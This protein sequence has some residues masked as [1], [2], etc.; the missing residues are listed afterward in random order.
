MPR[1]DILCV[2]I[3]SG[4]NWFY[5]IISIVTTFNCIIH[6]PCCVHC[7][8]DITS[9]CWAISLSNRIY[10]CC[11]SLNNIVIVPAAEC[12]IVV[13]TAVLWSLSSTKIILFPNTT[14]QFLRLHLELY[15]ASQHCRYH[16]F[17]III[18]ALLF[19]VSSSRRVIRQ[20]I[21]RG[22]R[23]RRI[24]DSEQELSRLLQFWKTTQLRLHRLRHCRRRFCLCLSEGSAFPFYEGPSILFHST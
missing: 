14:S 8:L 15:Y 7:R 3:R 6:Y 12:A 16:P 24:G 10:R 5:V 2:S 18:R 21:L 9:F 20:P 11:C 13:A 19:N 4:S 23:D 22:E 1:L 17:L